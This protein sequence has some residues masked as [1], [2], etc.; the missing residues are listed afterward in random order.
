M[1]SA[2]R[3]IQTPEEVILLTKIF[4]SQ[5][6]HAEIAKILD[7]ENVGLNS[8]IIQND[9]NFVGL[10]LAG[11]ENASMWS[12]GLAYAKSLLTIPGDE[13]G[14][15]ALQAHDDWAVWTMLISATENINDPK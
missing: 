14:R 15:E 4:E 3:A 13:A 1:L 9:W 11:L 5:G 12:E 10:K 6:R 2:P 7:T 8:P